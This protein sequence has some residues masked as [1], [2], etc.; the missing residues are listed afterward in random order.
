M[1]CSKAL[2]LWQLLRGIGWLLCV[3]CRLSHTVLDQK[4]LN[5][6]W[7]ALISFL[8]RGTCSACVTPRSLGCSSSLSKVYVVMD[9]LDQVALKKLELLL[10]TEK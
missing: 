10:V 4:P 9:G 6:E 7:S 1:A 8:V 3:T 5:G 2:L